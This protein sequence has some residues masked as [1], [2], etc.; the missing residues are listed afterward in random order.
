LHQVPIGAA[1]GSIFA[2]LNITG[3]ALGPVGDPEF[4]ASLP[5]TAKLLLSLYMLLGR[6]E[7]F[8]VLVLLSPAFWR[9]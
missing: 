7:I 6:L 4:Y 1:F 2:C 3:I 8:S 5:P 9:R